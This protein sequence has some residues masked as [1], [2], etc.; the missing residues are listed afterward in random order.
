MFL[1]EAPLGKQHLIHQDGPHAYSLRAAPPGFDSVRAVGK[2]QPSTPWD[3]IELDGKQVHLPQ[4]KPSVQ[5]NVQSSFQHDEFLVYDEAQVR[6]R[7]VV[8]VKL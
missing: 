4:N 8:T 3:F 6:I 5:D 1:C 7:Y 2:V